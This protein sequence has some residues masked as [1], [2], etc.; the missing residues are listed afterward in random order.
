MRIEIRNKKKKKFRRVLLSIL[1]I[2]ILGIGVYGISIYR[3]FSSALDT[4][5]QPVE[6][7]EKRENDISIQKQDPFS[8]LL[9]GV[10]ERANDIGR[11]DTII[12]MTVNPK[13][14][15]VKMLSV[16]RDTRTEIVGNGTTEKMNHAYTRGGI[17]MT[18][19]TVEHFLDIPID[20][21]IKVNLD[22]FKN[23]IDAL[24]GVTIIN[25]M[26]LSYKKYNFPKG[27]IKLNGK[28]ALVFSR[29]RY[30][31]PRGDF[32]RQ[33]RQKQIIQAILNEGSSISSLLKYDGV[34]NA[35]GENIKTNL[36]FKEMVGIQ[37]Q[38]KGLE[39]NIEQFQ[40]Q[41][42][43]GG[44]IGKYWYYFPDEEELSEFQ[45]MLKKHLLLM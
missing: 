31:D 28:E 32:G 17:N 38:Y 10:D 20:Y 21:Y 16:P 44:Y 11:P 4:M 39:K 43:D 30:E 6:K 41:N 13:E 2:F 25:D 37:Q 9:L 24:N 27:E 1:F 8:V 36:T 35:L 3:S 15:T 23:I 5:H 40:F 42:G 45:I 19:A 7:S 12:V 29:I 22:G 26:D 18:I 33:I 14:E 34:F